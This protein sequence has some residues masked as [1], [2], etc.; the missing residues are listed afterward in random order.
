MEVGYEIKGYRRIHIYINPED[1]LDVAKFI[2]GALLLSHGVRRDTAV[3]TRLKGYWLIALGD[4][5]RHLRPDEETLEGW[6]KAVLRGAKLGVILAKNKPIYKGFNICLNHEGPPLLEMLRMPRREVYIVTYSRVEECN[7]TY[8][9]PSRLKEYMIAPLI[10]III[11]N[12]EL[13][14]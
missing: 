1:E 12:L 2:A 7:Y 3:V 13:S 8:R 11:D 6:I 14:V 4:R 9:K 10:N 5:V